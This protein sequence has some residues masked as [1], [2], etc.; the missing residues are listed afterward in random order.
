MRDFDAC[1]WSPDGSRPHVEIPATTE[2]T[3]LAG[4]YRQ[5]VIG[6]WQEQNDE[7]PFDAVFRLVP[8][9]Y[10]HL[11]AGWVDQLTTTL[12]DGAIDAVASR[13]A[14]LQPLRLTVGPALVGLY[15]VELYVVPDPAADRLAAAVRAAFR[16]VLGPTAAPE[17][18]LERP[19][20]PHISFLYGQQHVDTDALASRLQY[21][22]LHPRTGRLVRPVTMPVA[23]VLLVDQDTWGHEGLSWNQSTAWQVGLGTERASR[24]G[25]S[26]IRE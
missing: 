20:C 7:R 21:G 18:A 22:T 8:D 6:W 23:S 5:Q 16:D 24:R 17:P 3:E 10:L 26:P 14:D 19:W 2:V 15:A 12:P 13:L 1:R 9:E 4:I 25:P 11:T